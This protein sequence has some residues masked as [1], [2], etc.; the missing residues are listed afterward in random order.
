[1]ARARRQRQQ[2]VTTM[3]DLP[4]T[5]HASR[6]GARMTPAERQRMQEELVDRADQRVLRDAEGEL[7]QLRRERALEA[8]PMTATEVLMRQR[9]HARDHHRITE[10]FIE[11]F[12]GEVLAAMG[13][14]PE[15][16]IVPNRADCDTDIGYAAPAREQLQGMAPAMILQDMPEEVMRHLEL[17][18]GQVFMY[19]GEE[20]RFRPALSNDEA[21]AA[22]K[23]AKVLL[24]DSLN[25]E[26]KKWWVKKTFFMAQGNVTGTWYKIKPGREGNIEDGKG[27]GYCITAQGFLPMS[28]IVLS[29]KLMIEGDESTF[30]AIARKSERTGPDIRALDNLQLRAGGVPRHY[31]TDGV[32]DRLDHFD[33][34]PDGSNG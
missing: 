13:M 8:R 32:F 29:Q 2:L 33:G 18:P 7:R 26:Q 3:P 12:A 28:D 17:T 21:R 23:R 20:I 11:Q 4:R 25:E 9:E 34:E 10:V 5:R 6:T 24:L 31:E 15:P 22:E 14:R 30:L 19:R 1:M 16:V 27:A